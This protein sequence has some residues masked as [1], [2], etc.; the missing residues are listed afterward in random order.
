M[1]Y[2]TFLLLIFLSCNLLV[3]NAQ[4]INV[5]TYNIRNDNQGDVANGN[6]WKQRCPVICQLIQFHK[7][8]I[9]GSQEVKKNQWDDMLN[10]MPE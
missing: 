9:F 7:F 6:G 10:A 4:Q 5:A 2:K 1:K 8:D 3:I